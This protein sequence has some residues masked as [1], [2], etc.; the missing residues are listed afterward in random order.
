MK[1]RAMVLLGVLLLGASAAWGAVVEVPLDC[2][3]YYEWFDTW[4]GQF[5][6]GLEFSQIDNVYVEW[7]GEITAGLAESWSGGVEPRDGRFVVEPY[8]GDIEFGRA[9]VNAGEA[10]YPDPEPFDEQTGFDYLNYARLLDGQAEVEIWL[11]QVIHVGDMGAYPGPS[12][13]LFGASLFIEGTIV[14]E[15]VSVVMLTYGVGCGL[16]R[17]RP[18]PLAGALGKSKMTSMEVNRSIMHTFI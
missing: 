13:D 4:T 11:N 5:D 16:L 1:T 2:A 7:S 14:P 15:P 3:G 6:L 8:E 9:A 17:R 10:T 12:G 18:A